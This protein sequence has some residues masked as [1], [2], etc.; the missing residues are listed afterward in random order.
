MRQVSRVVVALACAASWAVG[1]GIASAQKAPVPAPGNPVVVMELQK[2]TVTIE[3][4]PQEAPKTVENF[5]KLVKSNFYNRQHFHRVE[6]F[7]VQIG[8]PDSKNLNSK[9]S[10]GRRG[11]GQAIGVAEISPKLKHIKGAV[12]MAHAGDPTKAD[13]QFYIT[14]LPKKI[15]EGKYAIFGQVIS[16]MD[17]VDKI[18]LGDLVKR[19]YVK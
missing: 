14:K 3:L 4:Y 13:S 10:W 11:N 16:G 2:G 8:D 17:V 6:A 15:P 7:V 9:D 5:L 18:E 12:G 19:I 1:A